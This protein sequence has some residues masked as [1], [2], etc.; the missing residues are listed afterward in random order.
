MLPRNHSQACPYR[1]VEN[2]LT[3]SF[4]IDQQQALSLDHQDEHN[5]QTVQEEDQINLVVRVAKVES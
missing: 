5:R 4:A 2:H 3:A 1:C